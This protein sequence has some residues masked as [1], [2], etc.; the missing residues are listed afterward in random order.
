M[1]YLSNVEIAAHLTVKGRITSTLADG[2]LSP[3]SILSRVRNVNLNSDLLD[4]YEAIEF[5][6]KAE[7]AVITG[8]W[9]YINAPTI[10]NPSTAP[11]AAVRYDQLSGAI[12]GY[13]PIA[14][15]VNPG[16]G[17]S[18][19][20]PLSTNITLGLN[21]TYTDGRYGQT[22][23]P[24][25]GITG[26]AYNGSGAQTWNVDVTGVNYWTKT[27]S[28]L[29]YS[30]GSVN[31]QNIFSVFY[32][33]GKTDTTV[34]SV[35]SY[36]SNDGSNASSLS[37]SAK[38]A[39]SQANRVFIF[40]TGEDFVTSTGNISFQPY[41]GKILIGSQTPDA[42]ILSV[43]G[44][45]NS[46]LGYRVNGSFGSSGQFLKTSGS[47]N[48]Y[49][50]IVE[51]DV[52][53]LVSDLAAKLSGNGTAT[54]VPVYTGTTTFA[55][56]NIRTS[57]YN[58]GINGSPDAPLAV[59]Y[60]YSKTDTTARSIA[61]YVS[62][63]GTYSHAYAVFA[64]GAAS[65]ANRVIGFQ[66]LETNVVSDGVYSFQPYGGTVVIGSLTPNA[67]RLSVT[68]DIN[69][70]VGYRV[71]NSLGS[72]GQ[73]LKTTGSGN[74]YATILESDVTNLVSDLAAK[75]ALLS[76]TGLVKSVAGT[77]SYVTDNTTN[78]NA[79][80]TLSHNA[81]TLGTT[82]GLSLS[83]QVLSL[84]AAT[85][86]VPGALIAADWTTFNNK[87]SG[88]GTSGYVPNYTGSNTFGNSNIRVSGTNVGI[89]GSP[90]APLA[91]YYPN[92]KTDTTPRTVAAY[93][94]NDGTYSHAY[95]VFAIGAA[96]QANRVIGFQTLET[97]V[98]SAGVYSFQPYGGTVVIG[99]LTPTAY[100]LSVTGDVNSTVGYRVN[101]SFGSNGQFLKTNGSGNSYATIG[102]SDVTSLVSDLAAKQ[103]TLSGSGIV[104][105]AS[106]TISYLT[107]NSSNWN[108]AYGWGNHAGLYSLL[109][110]TH[111]ASNITDFTTA[112]RGLVSGT[113]VISYNSSTGVISYT[114]GAGAGTVG[115]GGTAGY[116]SQWMSGG[117]NLQNGRLYDSGS[118]RVQTMSGAGFE[119]A[120]DILAGGNIDCGVYTFIGNKITINVAELA[121]TMVVGGS[122]VDGSAVAELRSTSKGFLLPRMTRAQKLAI[123]SPATGLMIFQTDT[124]GASAQGVKYWTGA[125]WYHLDFNGVAG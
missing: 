88:N 69:T 110:H 26:S 17:M 60:P 2:G 3:F 93:L 19:G 25:T 42:S 109:G 34:R 115:G 90:D 74:V 31:V 112:G 5:P 91:V 118:G 111:T 87:L 9:D 39:A 77:I 54:Y 105:S 100:T 48:S 28:N 95:S 84:Q 4:G 11:N 29:F 58:V 114:G 65:Q 68:G 14:R 20:G 106:G 51:S 13:V 117:V 62:N 44:D 71:S 119:S 24:G 21:L 55:N 94:S 76:G 123:T 16:T 43:T 83:T 97:N 72:N 96:T 50:N 22:L 116:F 6:R 36:S 80:Y 18:G 86:S 99:S 64:V 101:G 61:S 104:K 85:A 103:A 40:Q 10:T 49:A 47:G 7:N 53:G 57:G 56:S 63:D 79:A 38:G 59:Y 12:A 81:L 113:G 1:K 107:D 78:W 67:A 15:Q 82:N 66:V 89:N 125:A 121:N 102:Q 41:G 92:S 124:V 8:N 122:S 45:I 46:T 98:A 73:F 108:T 120:G 75:Q 35:A 52:T 37:I 23:T 30:A 33:Y 70:T 27:G 32:Q